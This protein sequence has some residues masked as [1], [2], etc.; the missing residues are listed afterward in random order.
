MYCLLE[1]FEIKTDFDRARADLSRLATVARAER[2]V[3]LAI[4]AVCPCS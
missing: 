1:P 3:T 4:T 2:I